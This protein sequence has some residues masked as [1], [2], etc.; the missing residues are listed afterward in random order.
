MLV[1]DSTKRDKEYASGRFD[2]TA[3]CLYSLRGKKWG[4]G[5]ARGIPDVRVVARWM[6]EVNVPA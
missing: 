2:E 5:R 3:G 1:E 4:A 6:E